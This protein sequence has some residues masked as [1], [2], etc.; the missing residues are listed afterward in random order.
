[1]LL[2]ALT[3]GIGSGKSTVAEGLAARGAAI[4]DAD[5]VAREVVEPGGPAYAGVVAHFGPG[6]VRPDGTLDR[7]A[8][9]GLVFGDPEA[10]AELNRLTHP[11][12]GEVI[13]ER[14]AALEGTD[15]LV[16]LDVPLLTAATAAMRQVRG[17]IVVDVAEGIAVGRL[18][19][20]RGFTEAD[21]WARVTAQTSREERRAL[22]DL[23]LDNSGD[24]V[25]LEAE[26]DR[27]WA[28]AHQLQ[29]GQEL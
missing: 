14:L 26:I 7:P 13:A 28:W 5:R 15:R 9:A 8:L 17:V 1:V 24:R 6:V 10:L 27:A 20:H 19:A 11:V 3:G 25:A 18:V 16:V 22:A 2:I 4:V 23:V 21:A 12:I 29:A